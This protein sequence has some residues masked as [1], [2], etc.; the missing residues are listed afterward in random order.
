M[1]DEF[2]W[3]LL[4]KKRAEECILS[5]FKSFRD[6]GIEPILIKGWAAARNYPEKKPRFFGDIDLAV[7]KA[8]YDRALVLTDTPDSGVL[9]VDLHRELRHLDTLG[10]PELLS[11]SE[12]V[13]LDGDKVRILCPEDHLR[14]LCVH[15]L[16][17]GAES[18]ERLWDIAYAVQNRPAN[19]SWSKCL[20]VVSANRRG[21]I[22]STIGLAH[23]YL[24]LDLEGLPFKDE[25]KKLPGW[26]T[27]CVER[28]WSRGIDHRPLHTAL[29]DRRALMQQ[30]RKRIP[31]NPIQATI[32]CE[33]KFDDGSRIGYQ[34]RDVL[35]RL[36]PSIKRVVPVILGRRRDA[37]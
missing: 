19:F 28:E 6:A 14:V 8:D 32:D 25:A 5:S 11:N 29:K 9:G 7:S 18:R 23:K 27:R 24:G 34:L 12:L 20:D 2:R 10:W 21:W 33:G 13:D 31:P 35:I 3:Y 26:L 1:D 4:R 17:N 30:I 15:W 36:T 22:I 16:T 37:N